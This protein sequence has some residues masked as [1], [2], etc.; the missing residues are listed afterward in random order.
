MDTAPNSSESPVGLKYALKTEAYRLGFTLFGVTT[1][2]P[3]ATFPV[4]LTWLEHGR[5][6]SMAYLA[7]DRAVARRTDLHLILPDVRSVVVL[8]L[9]YPRPTDLPAGSAPGLHGRVAAYAWGADYHDQIPPRLEQLTEFLQ[10]QV[11]HPVAHKSYTDTGPILERD[12]ASR[13]GLGWMGKNTC[14]IN[15]QAGSFFLLA[16]LF[17]NLELEPDLPFTTDHCGSCRRCIDA[18]PTGCI[19]PDRTLDARRCISYHTIENKGPIPAE[20]RP[21]LGAWVFGCDICQQVCPWNERFASSE[22]DPGL[23]PQPQI[24]RPDLL[25][26]LSLTPQAFNRQFKGSPILRARRRGYLRNTAVALGNLR[27]AKAVPALAIT[28]QSESEP[29]VRAH[30]AWALGQIGGEAARQVLEKC[31]DSESDA[32][33]M[34]EITTARLACQEQG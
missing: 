25:A 24:A 20:L 11:R 7:A 26:A 30:A 33:V 15:P 14:L 12:L 27:D 1:P 29:L 21:Q 22:F 10:K 18:C 13:A 6:G 16:E 2:E 34:R 32:E 3:P 28:L 8:G 17:I 23:N 31:S 5:H 4:Y 19:L 9:R